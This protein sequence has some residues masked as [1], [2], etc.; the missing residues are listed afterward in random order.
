MTDDPSCVTQNNIGIQISLGTY[1]L[2]YEAG[3]ED[4]LWRQRSEVEQSSLDDRANARHE[5]RKNC[6]LLKL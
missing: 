2:F 6:A 5:E 3:T 1:K 4:I